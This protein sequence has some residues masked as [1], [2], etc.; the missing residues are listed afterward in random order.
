MEVR[1]RIPLAAE[2]IVLFGILPTALWRLEAAG[3]KIPVIPL[4]LVAGFF[5][6]TYLGRAVPAQFRAA[7]LSPWRRGEL[8]R[9]GFQVAL[10]AALLSVYVLSVHPESLFHF[11]RERPGTWAVLLSLYPLLSVL[12]QELLF[13]VFFFHRYGPLWSGTATPVLVSALVFGLAHL[14]Y[15]SG[16]AVALATI[17]GLFFSWTFARTGS[18]LLVVVEHSL[19]GALLFTIG[20]GGH[21]GLGNL[22]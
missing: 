11:P 4:L 19:Y 20:L 9:I 21:F 17:G 7:L 13:R 8:A 15:G 18:L 5:V 2:L 1:Q 16:L 12:P 14:V 6:A 10:G 22:S 3:T